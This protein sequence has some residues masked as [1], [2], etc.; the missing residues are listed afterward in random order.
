MS[1]RIILVAAIALIVVVSLAL[2]F[3]LVG[4]NSAISPPTADLDTDSVNSITELEKSDNP[5]PDSTTFEDAE[6]LGIQA[7][8][9]ALEQLDPQKQSDSI[10]YRAATYEEAY[11][12]C[13]MY[14]SSLVPEPSLV[15]PH[16]F[17]IKQ[18]LE[19]AL[20]QTDNLEEKV[21]LIEILVRWQPI[22]QQLE[23][24]VSAASRPPVLSDNESFGLEFMVIGQQSSDE[25]KV[26]ILKRFS[27]LSQ[28]AR[29]NHAHNTFQLYQA[30]LEIDSSQGHVSYTEP[31]LEAIASFVV[32]DIPDLDGEPFVPEGIPEFST[33]DEYDAWASQNPAM[34][35]LTNA[36]LS[37]GTNNG[38][39]DGM[40]SRLGIE[41]SFQG[42]SK[43]PD[44]FA[45]I[46]EQNTSDSELYHTLLEIEQYG[47][48]SDF[49]G[50]YV[51]AL[52]NNTTIQSRVESLLSN[53]NMSK[54]QRKAV[55][56][57]HQ[58]FWPD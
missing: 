58:L 29:Q 54:G 1:H 34:A 32:P 5:N 51:D 8:L 2:W 6:N 45:T 3:F 49:F 21:Q 27:Q 47:Q 57:L 36:A 40:F 53:P 35:E 23:F 37:V 26:N 50:A 55:K 30:L 39:V 43:T 17:E 18:R 33:Q 31:L 38:L 25:D 14:L 56:E 28:P 46:V 41:L 22:E 4:R 44:S 15:P 48:E 42:Q 16:C 10:D 12:V 11:D 52:Q 24:V 7:Q 13:N 19:T 20:E 9:K